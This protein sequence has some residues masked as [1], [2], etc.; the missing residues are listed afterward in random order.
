MAIVVIDP[1]HGGHQ[2]IGGSDANHAVS[3]SGMLEKNFTLDLARRLRWSLLHGSAKTYADSL[4]KSVQVVLTRDGDTNL[5]LDARATVAAQQ[6]AD[7]FLSIHCNGWPDNATRKI[8]GTE[9]YVDRKYVRPKY[10]VSAGKAIAQEG[11]GDRNS[12]LR[13]V[14]VDADASFAA[15]MASAFVNALSEYDSGAKLRSARY[16]AAQNGEAW[17]RWSLISSATLDLI[18]E[19]LGGCFVS[20][21]FSWR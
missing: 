9:A 10:V 4:G 19:S 16:T 21:A 18:E 2:N 7:L 8:R 6:D 12:G 14:N 17:S 15:A 3:G 5:G 13:N 11:P 20:E 1:G